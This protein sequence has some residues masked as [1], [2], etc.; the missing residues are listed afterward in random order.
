LQILL[1]NSLSY[2]QLDIAEERINE[3][4]YSSIEK[5]QRDRKN[6]NR[7]DTVNK[8]KLCLIILWGPENRKTREKAIFN[9]V[10]INSIVD[11]LK[12][13]PL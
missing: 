10:I 13:D 8:P 2:K 1:L 3:G 9:K 6:A 5:R 7:A 11:F 12:D 4:K